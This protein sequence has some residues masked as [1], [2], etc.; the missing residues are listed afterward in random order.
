MEFTC[1]SVTMGKAGPEPELAERFLVG[2]LY[3]A[4]SHRRVYLGLCL[5][6]R[7]P[8]PELSAVE[9]G[10]PSFSGVEI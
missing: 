6:K 9:Q 10:L 5:L 4:C 1:I 8:L 2:P 3:G 7:F